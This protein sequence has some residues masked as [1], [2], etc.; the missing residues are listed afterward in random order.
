MLKLKGDSPVAAFFGGLYLDNERFVFPVKINGAL[1][2]V[3]E[4]GEYKPVA[5]DQRGSRMSKSDGSP[6]V[7]TAYGVRKGSDLDNLSAA[8]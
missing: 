8:A 1:I 3:L 5:T 4:N 7:A 2:G 6:D